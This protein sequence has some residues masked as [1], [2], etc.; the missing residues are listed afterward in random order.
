[1]NDTRIQEADHSERRDRLHNY[2]Y[3]ASVPGEILLVISSEK[4][5]KAKNS[6]YVD[7]F[8]DNSGVLLGS[9]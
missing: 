4:K 8:D 6:F 7:C 5:G 2:P 3:K 1:M 9:L